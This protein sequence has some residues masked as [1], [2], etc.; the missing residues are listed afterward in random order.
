MYCVNRNGRLKSTLLSSLTLFGDGEK[1]GKGLAN[2]GATFQVGANKEDDNTI[3]ADAE[4]FKKISFSALTKIKS[5]DFS[6]VS[7]KKGEATDMKD[8]YKTALEDLDAAIDNITTVVLIF[9]FLH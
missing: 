1:D 8:G 9:L 3:K 4:L 6:L 2:E 5:G 7:I